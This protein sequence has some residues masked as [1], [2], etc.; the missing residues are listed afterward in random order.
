MPATVVVGAQ[1]GDEGK[2]KI[3]DVLSRSADLVVRFQGGNNAGHTIVVDGER[4]A[5]TLIPS[6]VLYPNVTPVI[7]NGCVVDPGV[8]LDEMDT[9]TGARRRSVPAARVGKR[10]P[11][12]A[13]PPQARRGDGALPGAAADRDHQAGDRPGGDGQVRPAGDQGAGPVRPEDLPGQARGGAQGPQPDP[14]QGLQP[15]PHG[16]GAHRRRIPRL[17]RPAPSPRRRHVAAGL[18][19]DP[20]RAQRPVRGGPG[21][22]ARHRPRLLPVRDLVEPDG[23]RR[24]RRRRRSGR[25]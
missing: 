24:L 21:D 17:R 12:H 1:W 5:L 20:R 23:R 9:L 19:G 2:G 14:D 3:T 18:G 25:P 7:A 11:D 13:V 16:P 10:P 15:A 6:G 4:F 22:P 8:L